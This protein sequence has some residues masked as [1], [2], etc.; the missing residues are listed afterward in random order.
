MSKQKKE[1]ERLKSR[2]YTFSY[3]RSSYTAPKVFV[4]LLMYFIC[5]LN[6]MKKKN[7]RLLFQFKLLLSRDTSVFS[8]CICWGALVIHNVNIKEQ[9][10]YVRVEF[11]YFGTGTC[12]NG[13]E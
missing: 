9:S 12:A 5:L 13:L 2:M 10:I 8:F 3:I 1:T 7:F 4:S 11:I 6:E